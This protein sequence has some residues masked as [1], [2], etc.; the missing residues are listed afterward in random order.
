[1]GDEV[2]LKISVTS[3]LFKNSDGVHIQLVTDVNDLVYHKV[4]ALEDEAVINTLTRL[5]WTQHKRDM[6]DWVGLDNILRGMRCRNEE[7]A[8]ELTNWIADNYETPK[9]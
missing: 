2:S 5:G 6:I 4:I 1:M 9:L 8:L 7:G 3:N